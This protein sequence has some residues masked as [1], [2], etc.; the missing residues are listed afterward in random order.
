LEKG[1]RFV[2]YSAKL[3]LPQERECVGGGGPSSGADVYSIV[4][5]S[6]FLVSGG[7]LKIKFPRVY[8]GRVI[9]KL[10]YGGPIEP[11]RG[12]ARVNC[13]FTLS[14]VSR[15]FATNYNEAAPC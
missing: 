13:A 11:G 4:Y 3:A 12:T 14:L 6:I 15:K 5:S 2:E 10:V 9:F 1:G 7:F 8:L